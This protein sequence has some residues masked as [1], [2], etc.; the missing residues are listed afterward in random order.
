MAWSLGEDS[1]DWSHIRAMAR[2]L[3]KG[4]YGTPS[5]HQ[6]RPMAPEPAPAKAQMPSPKAS[7][8]YDVVWVDGTMDGPI[9]DHAADPASPDDYSVPIP[10]SQEQASTPQQLK[11]VDPIAPAQ[12]QAGALLADDGLPFSPEFLAAIKGAGRS[13]KVKGAPKKKKMKTKSKS[14]T[15]AGQPKKTKG[16][17][18]GM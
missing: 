3:E 18:M 17:E 14:K 10:F 12:S 8:P 11:P 13:K 4:G 1:Y 15:V 9:G 2:E 5:P 16:V 7:S 6:S